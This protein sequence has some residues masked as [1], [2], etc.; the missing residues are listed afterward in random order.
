M[1]TYTLDEVQDKL[2]GKIGTPE[3]DKFEYELQLDL[4]GE[5]IR[6]TRKER[7]LTQEELGKLIGVQK[8]QISRL[9]SNT[10]NATIDTLMKVFSALQAK[11]KLQIELPNA[12][13]SIGR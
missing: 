3:R 8:A 12:N 13:I 2:I 6:Q 11:V 9:E 5:A 7:N 4:I 1:R 10:S